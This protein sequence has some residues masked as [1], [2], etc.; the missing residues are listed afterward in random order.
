M[1]RAFAEYH[2]GGT[3]YRAQKQGDTMIPASMLGLVLG[4]M[5]H[6]GCIGIDPAMP[7]A[8]PDSYMPAPGYCRVWVSGRSPAEQPPQQSCRE[9]RAHL[10]SGATL[11]VGEPAGITAP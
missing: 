5:C 3:R 7:V 4:A 8:V 11:I 6:V 9:A 2:G 1:R 10:V